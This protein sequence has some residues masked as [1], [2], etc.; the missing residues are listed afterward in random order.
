MLHS[1]LSRAGTVWFV[2]VFLKV[3]SV[4]QHFIL[5]RS[6]S[7]SGEQ[8]T[9]KNRIVS[10]PGSFPP[11]K[12]PFY[13]IPLSYLHINTENIVRE[14]IFLLSLFFLTHLYWNE[15]QINQLC[16]SEVI[17]YT[18]VS[19][20]LMHQIQRLCC[21]T[22]SNLCIL[23]KILHRIQNIY[24]SSQQIQLHT[25]YTNSL[26]IS[27]K[28]LGLFGVFFFNLPIFVFVS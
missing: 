10:H 4:R 5:R 28:G 26:K 25:K 27:C 23:A 9:T 11:A 8:Q 7:A 18:F 2:S 22:I 13:I 6:S 15:S 1:V 17:F 21:M 16:G 3:L 14:W 24:L 20:F 12:L 19:G